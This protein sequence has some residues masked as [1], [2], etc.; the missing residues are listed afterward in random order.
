LRGSDPALKNKYV[1]FT[2]H[3]DHV[4]VGEPVNGDAIYNGAVDNASGTAALLEIARAPRSTERKCR[5]P[6]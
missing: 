4:G 5:S 1:V 2:A 3:A 6:G